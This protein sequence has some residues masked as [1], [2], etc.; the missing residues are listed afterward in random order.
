MTTRAQ[1][2]QTVW[3]DA[4]V[5]AEVRHHAERLCAPISALMQHAWT[6][7]RAWIGGDVL[8]PA[9]LWTASV[10]RLGTSTLYTP[11][12]APWMSYAHT[13]P[14]TPPPVAWPRAKTHKRAARVPAWSPEPTHPAPSR[15][16]LHPRPR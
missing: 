5:W 1:R 3:L 7:A 9:P 15:P 11:A 10:Q 13:P 16:A 12:P 8:P 6:L 14:A 4:D 2:R